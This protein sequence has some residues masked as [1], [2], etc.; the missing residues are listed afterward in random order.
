MKRIFTLLVILS[1]LCGFTISAN[2]VLID[3]GGGMIYST[4][5]NVTWLQDANYARTSGYDADGMMNWN[6][7]AAWASNLVYGGYDDWRLPTFDPGNPS[8]SDRSPIH[9]MGYLYHVELGNPA[10]GGLTNTGPF[11]NVLTV[12]PDGGIY[13]WYWSGTDDASDTTRAW[14]FSFDCG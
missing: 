5:L 13:D 1:I 10:G 8:V 11:I 4:D 9:E 2:A 6:D 12:V 14:R 3:R 7:A